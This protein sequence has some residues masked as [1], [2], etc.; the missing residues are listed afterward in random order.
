MQNIFHF[1][2]DKMSTNLNIMDIVSKEGS[3]KCVV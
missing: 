2:F 3:T 1:S